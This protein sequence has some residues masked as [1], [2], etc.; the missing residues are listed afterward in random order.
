MIQGWK[1]YNMTSDVQSGI[2]AWSDN[3]LV[4]YLSSGHTE[5]R[6]TAAGPMGLVFN[7][8]LRFLTD[9]DILAMAAYLK[10]IPPM[11]DQADRA[12]SQKQTPTP[13]EARRLSQQGPAGIDDDLGLRVFEG[14]CASCHD[15]DGSGVHSPYA[16]LTGNRTVNDPSGINL[17]QVILHGA[18]LQTRQGDK[19]MP[20]FGAGYSDA[21]IAAVVNY[22]TGRFGIKASTMTPDQVAKRRKEK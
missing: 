17:T 21:E 1:A 18:S 6:S 10:T 22:V 5:G 2:G 14:A 8:S 11:H 9:G 20:A 4:E 7:Y 12:V 13:S 15:W 3:E 16:D 19:F